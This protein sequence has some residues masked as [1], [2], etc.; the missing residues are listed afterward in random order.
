MLDQKSVPRK[1]TR[2]VRAGSLLIGG[3]APV[4]IQSMTNLP[5]EDVKGTIGQIL[6]LHNEGAD[7][8]RIAVRNE[9]SIKYLR[10]IRKSVSI[11]L[12]ADIHFNYRIAIKA[13]EAG[14]DKIRINPGNI[15]NR[16]DVLEVVKAAN[17]YGVPIRIGVNAGSID[18]KRY[19]A[20]T[21]EALIQSAFDHIHILEDSGFSDIVVSIKSSDINETI[22][23]N[24]LFSG[25]SDYPLHIGLTEAGYGTACIVQSSIAIGSLLLQG[26]GDTVRV[27]MTGDPVE[28]VIIAKRIL[29]S[30][31]ERMPVIKI[32]SCPTCGRTDPSFDVLALAKTVDNEMTNTF[33]NK[34]KELGKTITI[35]VMGCEVNGPGE[36]SH[37]DI[38]VAGGRNGS[39]LLFSSGKKI[40]K[41]AVSEAVKSIEAEIEKIISQA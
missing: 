40:K 34:L 14:I 1:K 20:V 31:G 3:D 15:G 25:Q 6:R 8:V 17:S 4:S 18:E 26:I 32:I 22:T 27:S 19:G 36:A 13:I 23:A 24:R 37:A 39:A 29:E 12:S 9:E 21:P 2:Q 33:G 11:P 28:E 35:A 41:I 38:G 16:E 5:I 30:T 10:E 7:L